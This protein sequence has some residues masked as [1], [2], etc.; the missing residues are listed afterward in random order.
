[1]IFQ[2]S[3]YEI[4]KGLPTQ[5]DWNGDPQQTFRFLLRLRQNPLSVLQKVQRF[6]AL[7]EVVPSLR[8]QAHAPR[9]APQE[10]HAEFGFQ[11]RQPTAHRRDG[12]PQRPRCARD[13][14]ELGD[15][16]EYQDVVEGG[17][18]STLPFME[19]RLQTWPS[20]QALREAGQFPRAKH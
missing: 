7:A 20:N 16:S 18:R 15:L 10:R 5:R 3:G 19:M 9:G 14:L 17:H 11:Q 12:H 1:M 6:L 8:G 2:E 4:Y 13:A